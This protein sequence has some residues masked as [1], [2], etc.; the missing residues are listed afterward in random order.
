[1]RKKEKNYDDEYEEGEKERTLIVR[2][3]SMP[4]VITICRT[5]YLTY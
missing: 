5:I 4:S 1:M 3:L 2:R